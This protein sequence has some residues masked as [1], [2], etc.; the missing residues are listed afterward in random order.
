MDNLNLVLPEIFMSLSRGRD[1][2]ATPGPSIIPEKVLT[3]MNRSAPNI[4]EGE[5]I[6]IT[7]SILSDLANFAGTTG[8]VVLYVANGHGV[9]EAAIVNLFEKGD[10]INVLNIY[11]IIYNIVIYIN[12]QIIIVNLS[13][14]LI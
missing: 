13:F 6:A 3:A 11:N 4:Y 1:H 10:T 14:F 7:E 8:N 5:I 9:W 12:I 2:L